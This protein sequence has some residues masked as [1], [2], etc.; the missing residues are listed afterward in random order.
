MP[1]PGHARVC[2]TVGWWAL[3][4]YAQTSPKMGERVS[5]WLPAEASLL[6]VAFGSRWRTISDPLAPCLPARCQNSCHDDNG[7]NL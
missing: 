4:S 7:L 5:S 6:L 2:V 3:R 1:P